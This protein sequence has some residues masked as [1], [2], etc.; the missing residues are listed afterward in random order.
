MLG[1]FSDRVG[2]GRRRL[3]SALIPV[4]TPLHLI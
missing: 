4:H 2:L 1:D 3:G